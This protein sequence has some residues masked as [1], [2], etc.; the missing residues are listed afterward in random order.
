MS[1]QVEITS[2]RNYEEHQGENEMANK[3]RVDSY[4]SIVVRNL[5]EIMRSCSTDLRPDTARPSLFKI[6]LSWALMSILTLAI[7]GWGFIKPSE[8]IFQKIARR[9]GR[10]GSWA[11]CLL[12]DMKIPKRNIKSEVKEILVTELWIHLKA[13]CGATDPLQSEEGGS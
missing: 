9:Y 10:G 12:G 1:D 7:S 11:R 2:V 6:S 8:A 13:F 3:N 5:R 4:A